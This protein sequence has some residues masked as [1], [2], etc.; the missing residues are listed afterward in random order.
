MYLQMWRHK[1]AGLS[2]QYLKN[3][4]HNYWIIYYIYFQWEFSFSNLQDSKCPLLKQNSYVVHFARC[5]PS[6]WEQPLTGVL[7]KLLWKSSTYSFTKNG[8]HRRFWSNE[9]IENFAEHPRETASVILTE[10]RKA[11]AIVC[12]YLYLVRKWGKHGTEKLLI[13]ICL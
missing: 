7:K 10:F 6:F 12:K 13:F 9:F 3:H 11:Q 4:F 5:L 1:E 2:R 8:L